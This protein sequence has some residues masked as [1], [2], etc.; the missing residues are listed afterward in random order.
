MKN[1][2]NYPD[3]LVG[4]RCMTYNHHAYIED[5]MNGFTMQ[6]TTFPF[7]CAII[8]DASTDG[9]PDVILRYMND[10]FDL[11]PES[12][13]RQWETDEARFLYAR[14]RQNHNCYFGI[15][16]LKTNYYSQRKSKE[17]L[18]TQWLRDVKYYALCEGD[19]YWIDPQKLQIQ[20]DYL[21]NNRDC[22]IIFSFVNI[23]DSNGDFINKQIPPRN[24]VQGDKVVTLS[25][26]VGLE[27]GKNIWAFQ[28]SSYV[29]RKEMMVEYRKIQPIVFNTI[30][31]GDMP[32]VLT[33]LL[34]G[35]GFVIK[36]FFSCYRWGM[37]V[38]STKRDYLE[39]TE[40]QLGII[41]SFFN[42]DTFTNYNYS[43]S[44]YKRVKNI[45]LS[46]I[47]EGKHEKVLYNKMIIQS[48]LNTRNKWKMLSFYIFIKYILF[49]FYKFKSYFRKIFH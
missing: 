36:D 11:A 8:D 14:H 33:S 6:Q 32:L 43:K 38:L 42:F 20:V 35:N 30:H 37:G 23:V 25:D 31:C 12:G 45:F 16:L 9:E 2:D 5:A 1:N 26:Y 47:W 4:V 44:I 13:A 29:F 24:C 19:D 48:I 41:D 18:M 40:I 22:T 3:F 15:V 49:Y 39:N 46:L 21:E 7:V 34:N 28:T 17:H 27:F 10:H